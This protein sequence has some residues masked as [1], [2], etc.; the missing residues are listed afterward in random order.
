MFSYSK[1]LISLWIIFQIDYCCNVTFLFHLS[2]QHQ[3]N[4]RDIASSQYSCYA[5]HNNLWFLNN[6]FKEI[7][8]DLI[9]VYGHLLQEKPPHLPFIFSEEKFSDREV[10]SDKL[11]FKNA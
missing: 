8:T 11:L 6:S 9:R 3:Y 10:F 2:T 4:F 5:I 7:C 1:A